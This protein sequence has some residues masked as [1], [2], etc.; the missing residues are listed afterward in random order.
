VPFFRRI[1]DVL[2]RF[3]IRDGKDD[4]PVAAAGTALSVALGTI[5]PLV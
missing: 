5:E 4:C 1:D 2:H 3:S